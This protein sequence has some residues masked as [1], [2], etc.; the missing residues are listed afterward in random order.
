MINKDL[1]LRDVLNM[2]KQSLFG[3]RN[4]LFAGSLWFLTCLFVIAIL[5]DVIARISKKFIG[6]K[7]SFCALG[8][9]IVLFIC[10]NLLLSP[11]KLFF[12]VDSALYYIL[13]YAIGNLIFPY[14]KIKKYLLLKPKSKAV[15]IAFTFVSF[16]ITGFVYF[17]GANYLLKLLPFSFPQYIRIFFPVIRALMIIYLIFIAVKFLT[18]MKLFAKMGQETLI[19]CG[20]E[21]IIKIIVPS[22][23]A[24]L[25]LS[26]RYTTPLVACFYIVFLLVVSHFTLVPFVNKLLSKL[27]SWLDHM[28]LFNANKTDYV[29]EKASNGMTV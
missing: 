6:S 21:Q 9:S 11:P 17:K 5:F 18:N 4:Q 22:I 2:C 28:K 19:F 7:W 14:I 16:V 13:F 29:E 10:C 3:I 24:M 1:G 20:T 8:I 12:N 15:F 23:F 27:Y 25:G 26:A